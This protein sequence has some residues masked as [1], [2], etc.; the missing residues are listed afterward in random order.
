MLLGI[1]K[2][3]II[4]MHEFVGR[5]SSMGQV[6]EIILEK[7]QFSSLLLLD[8][9]VCWK[10]W[11]KGNSNL[12]FEVEWL[13]LLSIQKTIKK[14]K[15]SLGNK[16]AN[17]SDII[18]L[19]NKVQEDILHHIADRHDIWCTK[20]LVSQH[21]LHNCQFSIYITKRQKNSNYPPTYWYILL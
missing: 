17:S 14:N 8:W 4:K 2:T 7:L 11:T 19:F 15:R 13:C 1:G 16:C 3:V 9:P 20:A 18:I 5:K 21:G 12:I 10:F 6:S